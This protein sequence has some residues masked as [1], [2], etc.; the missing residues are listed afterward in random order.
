MQRCLSAALCL[1]SV[2]VA[3]A[4]SGGGGLGT[5]KGGAGDDELQL[6]G[7]QGLSWATVYWLLNTRPDGVDRLSRAFAAGTGANEAWR[8]AF[9]GLT[10]EQADLEL[11]DYMKHGQ[12][13]YGEATVAK[14]STSVAARALSEAEVKA[15]LATLAAHALP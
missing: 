2:S 4:S 12:Y 15:L 1:A 9:P 13:A 8:Q 14:A 10:P 5:W 6:A 3:C 7:Y 11:H